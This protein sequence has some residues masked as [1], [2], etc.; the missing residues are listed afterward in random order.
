MNDIVD[1]TRNESPFWSAGM[2]ILWTIF[3]AIA[4]LPSLTMF[5]IRVWA[6]IFYAES[7]LYSPYV[8][9]FVCSL[10]LHVFVEK[11]CRENGLDRTESWVRGFYAFVLG[12]IAFLDFPVTALLSLSDFIALNDRLVIYGAFPI[13]LLAWLYLYFLM[14]RYYLLGNTRVF[15]EMI[16]PLKK[17]RQNTE[18]VPEKP[19]T[20]HDRDA[21]RSSERST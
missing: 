8:M 3:F 11:R 13:K 1:E 16:A 9:T 12:L 17:E 10:Y 15:A 19:L 20:A 18:A 21:S 14:L 2:V 7:L 4:F 5:V 6:G